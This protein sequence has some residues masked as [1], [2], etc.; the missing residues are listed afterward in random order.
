MKTITLTL[1]ENE[2][3]A[4]SAASS[5]FLNHITD[6]WKK[7]GIPQARVAHQVV[8]TLTSKIEQALIEQPTQ[9]KNGA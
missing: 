4:L 5:K 9:P 8:A 6:L 2:Q 7:Q 3:A 1:T